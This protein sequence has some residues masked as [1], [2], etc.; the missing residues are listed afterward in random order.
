M[1]LFKVTDG[2][3]TR[4][5]EA[6]SGVTFNDLKKKLSSVFPDSVSEKEDSDLIL[7]YRDSEGDV[8]TLSSDSELQELLNTT[9]QAVVKLYIPRKNAATGNTSHCHNWR[10][11]ASSLTNQ[12]ERELEELSS[13][14]DSLIRPNTSSP[15]S[16]QSKESSS[17]EERSTSPGANNTESVSEED[18]SEEV[19]AKPSTPGE[20]NPEKTESTSKPSSGN[21]GGNLRGCTGQRLSPLLLSD[22]LFYSPPTR[23]VGCQLRWTPWGVTCHC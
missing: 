2:S 3:Q 23:R 15:N 14:F 22:L 11:P 16:R 12:F 1:V 10:F 20:D 18:K 7:H 17:A 5:F 9:Q 6:P 8:I 21:N 4:R 19:S 13:L